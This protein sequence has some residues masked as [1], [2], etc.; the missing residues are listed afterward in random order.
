M[1]VI[2]SQQLQKYYEQFKSID[3]TFTKEVMRDIGFINDQIFIKILGFQWPCVIFSSSFEGAKII[4]NIKPEQMEKL[5][6]GSNLGSLRYSFKT[7]EKSEP[8]SFFVNVKI[9]SYSKY[10]S[11]APDLYF[12]T[13][14]ITQRPPDFMIELF[15]SFLSINVNS[16]KRKDERIAV[17]DAIFK[18]IGFQT[19]NIIVSVDK[20]DRKGLVRDISFGGAKILIPGIAKFLSGRSIVLK[21]IL[22]ENGK[23]LE[24]PGTIVRADELEGRKDITVAAIQFDASRIPM[25]FKTLINEFLTQ[26]RKAVAT[27]QKEKKE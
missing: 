17:N 2:T 7:P 6:T 25:E 13:L 20:I 22:I 18:K 24:I 8:L 23:T 1:A 11:Q 27:Q 15:G 10:N 21:P 14:E 5:R 12:M 26:L 19:I 4:L 9:K 3:I 16:H